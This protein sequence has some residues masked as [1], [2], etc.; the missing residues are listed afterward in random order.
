MEVIGFSKRWHSSTSED[1]A[2]E[3]TVKLNAVMETGGV[4]IE[5]AFAK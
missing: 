2:S 1:T 4:A 5:I 3:S